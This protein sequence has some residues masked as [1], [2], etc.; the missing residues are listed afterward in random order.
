MKL[1]DASTTIAYDTFVVTRTIYVA[2]QLGKMWRTIT[3]VCEQPAAMA[4]STNGNSF[5]P[6]ATERTVR[7]AVGTSSR[8]SAS[9]T[10]LTDCPRAAMSASARMIGG[11]A[12]SESTTRWL[13]ESEAP[14]T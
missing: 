10:L 13:P 7:A 6:S 2:R 9:T 1:S 14:P 4:A 3:R 8:R 5:T 12:I 11:S